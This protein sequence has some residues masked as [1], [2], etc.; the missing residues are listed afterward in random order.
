M[1]EGN[2]KRIVAVGADFRMSVLQV[3]IMHVRIGHSWFVNQTSAVY[4][5]YNL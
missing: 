1:S 2:A 5:F 4:V 3:L